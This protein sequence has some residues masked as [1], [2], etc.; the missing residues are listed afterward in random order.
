MIERR[1]EEMSFDILR[2]RI[3]AIGGVKEDRIGGHM[4]SSIHDGTDHV[5]L[6]GNV[7]KYPRGIQKW[8]FGMKANMHTAS[9][10]QCFDKSCNL[11]LEISCWLNK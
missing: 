2:E 11:L 6:I 10:R 3:M 1:L 9:Q 8:E 4:N 5:I 7:R